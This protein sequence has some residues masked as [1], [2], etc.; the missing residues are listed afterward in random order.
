[1][2]QGFN[3]EPSSI[4]ISRMLRRQ[5]PIGGIGFHS[6]VSSP[7]L[8][9]PALK[10]ADGGAIPDHPLMPHVGAIDTPT[11][12]RAD[13]DPMHVKPGSYVMP[14]DIVSHMG[15]GNTAAG[16]EMLQKMFLP[17]EAQARGGPQALMGA[18]APYGGTG[19]PYGAT[20]QRLPIGK[21]VGI[22]R[23]IAPRIVGLP[24][25]PV[26][27]GPGQQ[28]PSFVQAHGGVVPGEPGDQFLDR[29]GVGQQQQPGTP[30]NASGG[31]FVI[32]PEEVKRRGRGDIDRGHEI[33]DRWVNQLRADHIKTLKGLPG[34][35]K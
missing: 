13:L 9:P 32:P 31:E 16:Q 5:P 12:G 35:A 18:G 20:P 19:A 11:L 33:L 26:Y 2:P 34:P 27:A 28:G 21:G 7:A 30:I 4:Q 1:M 22:P 23:G 15:Q 10:R 29:L 17:L 8:R 3:P 6:M 24:K 14:A 25:Y